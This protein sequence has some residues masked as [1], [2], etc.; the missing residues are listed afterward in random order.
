MER[1]IVLSSYSVKGQGSNTPSDFVTDFVRPLR[2]DDNKRYAIG[3]NRIINMIFTW[4]NVN[5]GYN[6]Q[7]IRFS[8]DNGSTFTNIVFQPGVW[9]YSEFNEHIKRV[10]VIKQANKE[11]EFLSF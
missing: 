7:L 2:L 3:L 8:K 5:P 4:F 1:E 11:D 6:N 9:S 10:T